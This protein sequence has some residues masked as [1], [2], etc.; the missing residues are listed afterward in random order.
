MGLM[1]VGMMWHLLQQMDSQFQQRLDERADFI[2]AR[3]ID[4]EKLGGP[5]PSMTGQAALLD[6][7]GH[8]IFISQSLRGNLHNIDDQKPF[9][10]WKK[11]HFELLGTPMRATTKSAG[12][13]GVIWVALSEQSLKAV[14]SSITTTLITAL[15]LTLLPMLLLGW[16]MGKH[17]LSGLGQAATL[18]DQINP[19]RSLNALPLPQR[20]DEV[21]RLLTAINRLLKRIAEG[22]AREK[23][24]LGQIVHELGAPLTVLKASLEQAE[25]ETDNP[26]VSRAALV[27]DELTCTTQ[28]LMQL[29]RGRLE[30]T[31]ALHYI[32]AQ[33]L[34]GRLDRLVPN[35]EFLGNWNTAVLCDPDRLTQALRNLLANARRAAGPYGWV[36]IELKHDNDSGNDCKQICFRVTDNGAGIPTELE[37]QIFDPFVSG[38]GSSGLGLS[39]S[40]QIAHMHEGDLRGGNHSGGGAEFILTLPVASLSDD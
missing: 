8:P 27:T 3:F 2:A 14:H 31:L 28:D 21:H 39:V 1:G 4:I 19:A 37:E 15:I 24:L 23:Q 11:T 26:M 32:S 7:E 9:P 6:A 17:A 5:T 16:F 33:V 18:A 13:F 12:D 38:A 25:K 35:T 20:E 22:Q 36:K 10:Y 40:R 34:R 30:M 29:A